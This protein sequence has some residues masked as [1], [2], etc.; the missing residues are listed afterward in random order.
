ML[1]RIG[2][3]DV[4]RDVI[5]ALLL[6]RDLR[7]EFSEPSRRRRPRAARRVAGATAGRRDLRA[8][9]TFTIDPVSAR[10]FDDAISAEDLGDGAR[11]GLGAHRRCRRARE[12]GLARSIA[13]RAGARTSVYAPGTVE[14]MLPHALSSD[15][16]SLR[17]GRGPRRGHGRARGA[18]RGGRRSAA[19]HRSLIRSDARL[20]YDQVDRIFAGAERAQEPWA[21]PLARRAQGRSSAGGA[22]RAGGRAGARLAASRSSRSTSAATSS[23]CRGRSRRSPIA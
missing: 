18:R 16:C 15:A 14:P 7:R 19:F 2:R 9:P 8:M 21:A 10:D 5:E 11:E 20:D 4:A 23:R 3:P 6:D 22:A 17:P 12:R 1:R 13:R